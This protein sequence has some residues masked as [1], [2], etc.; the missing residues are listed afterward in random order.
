MTLFNNI[1]NAMA[2]D[3][4]KAEK[5]IGRPLYPIHWYLAEVDE[6]R[7][8]RGS[9][10]DYKHLLGLKAMGVGISINLCAERSQDDAIRQVGITP[11]N[12]PIMD[13]TVPS[14]ADVARLMGIVKEAGSPI[15]IHC[16]QGRGRTGCMAAAYRVLVDKWQPEDALKEAEQF[17]LS[18]DSQKEFILGLRLAQN[19]SSQPIDNG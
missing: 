7:L 19:N 15:F 4:G 1:E 17:G 2:A 13:N 12:I 5:L 14:E 16:E 6:G 8:W 11:F 9:W 3:I 10:P 18:L